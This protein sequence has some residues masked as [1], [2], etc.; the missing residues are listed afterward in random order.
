MSY[1]LVMNRRRVFKDPSPVKNGFFLCLH[2]LKWSGIYGFVLVQSVFSHSSTDGAGV[3]GGC[4]GRWFVSVGIPAEYCSVAWWTF[5]Y[6]LH[7]IRG[8]NVVPDHCVVILLYKLTGCSCYWP[9]FKLLLISLKSWGVSCTPTLLHLTN[10]APVALNWNGALPSIH[11][12][13]T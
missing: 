12:S 8:F 11:Y 13:L 10:S 9:S 4:F 2:R 3:C 1:V 6:L 5:I 7:L